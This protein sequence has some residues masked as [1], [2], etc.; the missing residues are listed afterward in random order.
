MRVE[1]VRVPVGNKLKTQG[2]Q[3]VIEFEVKVKV[4]IIRV[5]GGSQWD[6]A[7]FREFTMG[8]ARGT[9]RMAVKAREKSQRPNLL[10]VCTSCSC[11]YDK[12]PSLR[13]PLTACLPREPLARRRRP[14]SL[15]LPLTPPHTLSIHQVAMFYSIAVNRSREV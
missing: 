2:S 5:L 6:T 14:A 4:T 12:V 15:L 1:G 8:I 10:L 9:W 13:V 3:N 7:S 11:D